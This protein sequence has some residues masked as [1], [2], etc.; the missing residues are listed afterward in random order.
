MRRKMPSLKARWHAESWP[1]APAA[2]TRSTPTSTCAF[3]PPG[4]ADIDGV[5]GQRRRSLGG[6]SACLAP[7]STPTA[8][9]CSASRRPR[10]GSLD[11]RHATETH[12]QAWR[13]CLRWSEDMARA[14]PRNAGTPAANPPQ[15]QRR[16]PAITPRKWDTSP[17]RFR[18]PATPCPRRTPPAPTI[19]RSL[20]SSCLCFDLDHLVRQPMSS[21]AFDVARG[22]RRLS[23]LEI[24]VIRCR[25]E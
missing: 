11:A 5:A 25:P 19:S 24:V 23:E 14:R 6:P 18:M 20:W 2:A 22:L 17:E 16:K 21:P 3:C 8:A 10:S 1:P 13:L 9:R 4:E 15:S 12:S 7:R